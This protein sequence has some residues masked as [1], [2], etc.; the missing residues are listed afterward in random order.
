MLYGG[1]ISL[2][3][4]V[5]AMLISTLIGVVVGTV[6]GYFR[7]GGQH[8]DAH[9]GRAFV[10]S[11]DDLVTVISIYMKPGLQ[12]IILVIGLFQ[13]MNI[14]RLVR[15]ETLSVKEREYVLYATPSISRTFS[16]SSG[17]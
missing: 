1:R 16:S 14:A 13:W 8:P 17:M 5:V 3:V 9:C 2:I 7:P 11:V 12:A 4:G 15:A 10:H 6:S